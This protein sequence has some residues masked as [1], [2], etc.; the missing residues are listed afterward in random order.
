MDQHFIRFHEVII[1]QGFSTKKFADGSVVE[2]RS[3][4]IDDQDYILLIKDENNELF[5][6]VSLKTG[7]VLDSRTKLTF[8]NV[9]V[10]L[11]TADLYP[12]NGPA[13]CESYFSNGSCLK[14]SSG[15]V[16]D[17]PT[18]SCNK[19]D[20]VYIP[21]GPGCLENPSSFAATI[22]KTYP[23]NYAF[24]RRDIGLLSDFPNVLYYS[25]NSVVPEI[26]FLQDAFTENYV[27]EPGA[28]ILI[29]N[30][31]AQL[32]DEVLSLAPPA[33]TEYPVVIIMTRSNSGM[34]PS[35]FINP[36]IVD[37]RD[38]ATENIL[39]NFTIPDILPDTNYNF[40]FQIP[41]YVNSLGSPD[42][43]VFKN[44]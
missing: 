37:G 25:P 11:R 12:L 10:D 22:T 7:V 33:D 39:I 29:V 24:A 20:N 4:C 41:E 13:N 38:P 8:E 27:E 34:A 31:F 42:F 2:Q 14:C 18:N 19:C 36:T 35:E 43:N 6:R 15:Y 44:Y 26:N 5:D 40:F 30:V 17:Y 23:P 9:A 16:I 32:A 3:G 21:W 28:G 1:L